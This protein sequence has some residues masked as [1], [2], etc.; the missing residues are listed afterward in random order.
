MEA[1]Y[2]P[3]YLDWEQAAFE[4]NMHCLLLRKKTL[5]AM[6]D[7]VRIFWKPRRMYTRC[8]SCLE[9]FRLRQRVRRVYWSIPEA[10]KIFIEWAQEQVTS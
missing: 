6:F 3:R 4:L 8:H 10:Q 7:P 5:V 1:W 2:T 9:I